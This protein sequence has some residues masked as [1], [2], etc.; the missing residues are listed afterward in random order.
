LAYLTLVSAASL[1]N[2]LVIAPYASVLALTIKPQAACENMERLDCPTVT[3]VNSGSTRPSTLR[4]PACQAAHT[5]ALI[6]SFMAHHQ[7]MSFVSLVNFIAGN[8]MPRR[9]ESDP[10]F[11]ATTL[12]LQERVPKVSPFQL[13][14]SGPFTPREIMPG[15]EEMFRVFS[16]PQTTIPEVHLLS[17]GRYHVMVTNA[18]G[19]YSRWRDLAVTRWNEDP[20]MDNCGT[21]VYVND[22]HHVA[23]MVC[24]ISAHLYRAEKL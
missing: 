15:Q 19:G 4:P 21:F 16:T 11:Q 14:T 22:C 7:G 5:P 9:F 10:L 1:A 23:S 17:N 8:P 13:Q 24:G 20:T 18:G 2:D 12:L 6:R 3:K